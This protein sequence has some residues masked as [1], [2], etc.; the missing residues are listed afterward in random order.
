MI[1]IF[2]H[3]QIC[4]Q[5]GMNRRIAPNSFGK[6]CINI[7]I[8]PREQF[9]TLSKPLREKLN[10]L[11]FPALAQP[12][13]RI[14]VT[15]KHAKHF[16]NFLMVIEIQVM[17]YDPDSNSTKGRRTL[18]ISTQA[19]RAMGCVFCA[20]VQSLLNAI[21]PAARSLRRSCTMRDY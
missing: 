7:F 2:P 1:L 20:T 6:V 17:R 11:D 18:C 13:S 16:S 10:N 9:T 5:N 3:S 19:G 4:L 8:I 21:S 14:P 12:L 15:V